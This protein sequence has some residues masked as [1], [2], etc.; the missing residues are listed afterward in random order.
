VG[1]ACPEFNDGNV[2]PL[3]ERGFVGGNPALKICGYP[4][5]AFGYDNGGDDRLILRFNR[6]TGMTKRRIYVT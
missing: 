3:V 4:I 6:R 5:K 2:P 1:Q